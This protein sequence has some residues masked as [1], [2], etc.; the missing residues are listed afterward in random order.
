MDKIDF[1]NVDFEYNHLVSYK[2]LVDFIFNELIE[3]NDDALSMFHCEFIEPFLE[4][5]QISEE[6]AVLELAEHINFYTDIDE[7]TFQEF[8]SLLDKVYEDI[9]KWKLGGKI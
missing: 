9:P 8:V 2:K 5:K 6:D 4:L 7:N 3:E 1:M